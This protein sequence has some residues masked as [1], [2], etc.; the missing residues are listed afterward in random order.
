MCYEVLLFATI[1][2]LL[3][4]YVAFTYILS[5]LFRI[6]ANALGQPVSIIGFV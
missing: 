1:I 3:F 6:V 5:L 2:I 4:I